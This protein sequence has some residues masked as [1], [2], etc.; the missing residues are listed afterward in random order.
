MCIYISNS[1]HLLFF[2][3]NIY[4]EISNESHL[5][6]VEMSNSVEAGT[7]NNTGG[8]ETC[9]GNSTKAEV[10]DVPGMNMPMWFRRYLQAI[11]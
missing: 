9:N 8:V 4:W 1:P 3:I 6:I 10:V 11:G 5:Q 2:P 7:W